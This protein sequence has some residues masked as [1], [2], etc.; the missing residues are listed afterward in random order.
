[1]ALSHKDATGIEHYSTGQQGFREGVLT[2]DLITIADLLCFH[3][4]IS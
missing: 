3:V 4:A 1:M 2:L